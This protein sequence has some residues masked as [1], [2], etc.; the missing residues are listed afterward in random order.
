MNPTLSRYYQRAPRFILLPQDNYFIRVAGPK[1][2]PWEEGTEI[3]NMSSTGL[4]FTAP[5]DLSPD[6]GEHIRIQFTVPSGQQIATYA[7][8]TRLEDV[9]NRSALVAVKYEN[10]ELAQRLTIRQG[11]NQR[12]RSENNL[13]SLPMKLGYPLEAALYGF[14]SLSLFFSAILLFL[15]YTLISRSDYIKILSSSLLSILELFR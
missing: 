13:D 10:L 12:L 2:V 9:G 11:V 1:Q 5:R 7:Q 8:V 3:K 4:A 6:I 14:T 15:I